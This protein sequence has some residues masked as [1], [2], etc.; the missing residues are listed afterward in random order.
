[1]HSGIRPD[2]RCYRYRSIGI[3]DGGCVGRWN[4][5]FTCDFLTVDTV[6][7]FR[8]YVFF[9]QRLKSCRIVQIEITLNPDFRFIRNQ[10]RQIVSEYLHYLR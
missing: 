2:F 9:I 10:I 7:F 1:M 6:E 3:G 5:L 8:F 4:S